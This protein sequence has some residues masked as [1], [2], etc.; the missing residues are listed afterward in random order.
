VHQPVALAGAELVDALLTL[1]RG[2]RA[3]PRVLPVRLVVR[4]S[5][6]LPA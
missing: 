5:A 1:L 3:A 6:P 2:E 4:D